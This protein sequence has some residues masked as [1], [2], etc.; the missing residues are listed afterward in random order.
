MLIVSTYGERVEIKNIN[1]LEKIQKAIE[2]EISRQLENYQKG[3]SQARETLT[4]D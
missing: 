3:I 2:Y 4:F 1:S